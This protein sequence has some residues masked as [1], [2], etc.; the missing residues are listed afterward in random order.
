MGNNDNRVV[1]WEAL[2][3]FITQ[4]GGSPKKSSGAN[5]LALKY[6]E[7][8]EY[9]PM[10]TATSSG[11]VISDY[12]GIGG[13]AYT[14]NQLVIEKDVTWL[15]YVAPI[16]TP[17][18]ITVAPDATLNPRQTQQ[19][20][21]VVLPANAADKSVTWSSENASVATVD[22]NGLVTAVAVGQPV[23]IYA[24]SN[25]DP[26]VK[27]Y[28]TIT[29]VAA[30]VTRYSIS[31]SGDHVS[32]PGSTS[33]VQQNEGTSW[34][35]TFVPENGYQI[36][37]ITYTGQN[38]S[39]SGNTVTVSD[40]RSDVAI[41]VT[42]S[43]VVVPVNRY[44]IS[45]VG[46]H[47]TSSTTIP[48]TLDEG[49]TWSGT[50]TPSENYQIDSITYTG[51]NVQ[52]DGNTVSVS[53]L[54]S[55]V[56]ITITT[57][58]IPQHVEI[59][60]DA[61][62]V[63]LSI[64]ESKW[65]PWQLS[66]SSVEM[67]TITYDIEDESIATMSTEEGKEQYVVGVSRG[68]TTAVVTVNGE[69]IDTVTIT[70]NGIFDGV[71]VSYQ[72]N[73]DIFG[74][75][76]VQS[77]RAV[78]DSGNQGWIEIASLVPQDQ[79]SQIEK[80]VT[81]EHPE[82][83]TDWLSEDSIELLPGYGGTIDM[84]Y[85]VQPYTT[86][87]DAIKAYAAASTESDG[88]LIVEAT[89][90]PDSRNVHDTST[91]YGRDAVITLTAPDG[92]SLQYPIHQRSNISYYS[93]T[94]SGKSLDFSSPGMAFYK[95]SGSKPESVDVYGTPGTT[96]AD[97][98]TYYFPG[99][100]NI[101]HPVGISGF[102]PG[103]GDASGLV[104]IAHF[105]TINGVSGIPDVISGSHGRHVATIPDGFVKVGTINGYAIQWS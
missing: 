93:R 73:H 4:N 22:Q 1:T 103:E 8:S 42:T 58:Q 5:S 68:E 67:T 84:K 72:P 77:N 7:F 97:E 98:S 3:S 20:T 95:E 41:T 55:D 83:G 52:K 53:N 36:D 24:T 6:G 51:N 74:N 48:V 85:T 66:D 105:G 31:W 86:A 10:A 30:P 65:I 18:S 69:Y 91:D 13:G 88:K 61:D 60:L 38:V 54:T 33:P 79:I 49:S 78:R 89:Y 40:L 32:I 29:V 35:G 47:V 94:N 101:F 12:T 26:S 99:S 64:G 16:V 11:I 45:M 59:T 34:N 21:A 87:I 81:F 92:S 43:Q 63:E 96:L 39:H 90:H 19:L 17:S 70:V 28:A 56:I 102:Q 27:G 62:D 75:I 44:T 57:S 104:T 50:F 37:N 23:K 71:D 100:T 2:N 15:N 82:Y 25:A 14:S 76:D 80:S 9:A 46:E